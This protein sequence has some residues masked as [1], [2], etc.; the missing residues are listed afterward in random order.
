MEA[1]HLKKNKKMGRPKN[2]PKIKEVLKG[3]IPIDDI[4]DEEEKNIYEKYVDVYLRDFDEEL[5][6]SD[7]DDVISLATNRVLEIRLLKAS[8]GNS[9]KQID[10]S[11]AI[12]KLRKQTEKIKDNLLSRRKDRIDPHEHKGFSIIDLAVSFDQQ[13][14]DKLSRRVEIHK[15]EEEDIAT[16]YRKHEG[17]RYDLD[18]KLSEDGKEK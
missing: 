5:T 4:F 2:P 15:Q 10:T 13:K 12:E 17:N 6:S 7:M 1:L 11:T 3:I 14:R 8:K 18:V 9:D 16:E